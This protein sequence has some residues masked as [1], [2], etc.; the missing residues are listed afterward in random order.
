MNVLPTLTLQPS[1]QRQIDIRPRRQRDG[2]S[3]SLST[4]CHRRARRSKSMCA[5]CTTFLKAVPLCST[6]TLRV[7][8]CDPGLPGNCTYTMPTS[9]IVLASA[10]PFLDCSVGL[11]KPR[12]PIWFEEVGTGAYVW[13]SG[14]EASLSAHD[15]RLAMVRLLCKIDEHVKFLSLIAQ[16]KRNTKISICCDRRW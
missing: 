5:S 4:H 13:G 11:H 12:R 6:I 2:S 8:D 3:P 1:R 9:N 10:L 15:T 16:D 7:S 14:K